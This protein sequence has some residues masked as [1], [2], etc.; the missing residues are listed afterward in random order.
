MRG[1]RWNNPTNLVEETDG[2][3]LFYPMPVK[4]EKAGENR[5]FSFS[6]EIEAEGYRPVKHFISFN[7]ISEEKFINSMEVNSIYQVES[8]YLFDTDDP[9]EIIP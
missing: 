2:S 9:E 5:L 7:L 4:A 8:V 1:K 3:F 6:I